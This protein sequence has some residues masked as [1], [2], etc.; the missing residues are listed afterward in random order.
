[1]NRLRISAPSNGRAKPRQ[2]G[3]ARVAGHPAVPA[4]VEEVGSAAATINPDLVTSGQVQQVHRRGGLPYVAVLKAEHRGRP[5]VRL[6]L[7][8]NARG[9]H[10]PT[11]TDGLVV[12]RRVAFDGKPFV[13]AEPIH[14]IAVE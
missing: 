13:L 8:V 11:H 3:P 6:F 10:Q 7:L 2:L 4:D 12:G 14:L 9:Y 5:Y 1:M